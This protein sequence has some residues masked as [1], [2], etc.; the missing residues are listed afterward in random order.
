M[1][2]K[3]LIENTQK[4]M[5]MY[6]STKT[7]IIEKSNGNVKDGREGVK[8]RKGDHQKE[9]AS[10]GSALQRFEDNISDMNVLDLPL[11]SV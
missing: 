6:L 10:G 7:M 2:G 8:R 5:Q 4:L 3:G 11:L 1:T 9:D